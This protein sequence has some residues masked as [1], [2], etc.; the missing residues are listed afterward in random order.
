MQVCALDIKRLFWCAKS[1]LGQLLGQDLQAG[2]VP[3][4]TGWSSCENV[5]SCQLK[6][7]GN[8]FYVTLSGQWGLESYRINYA[9]KR[10]NQ[11]WGFPPRQP[12]WAVG[13]QWDCAPVSPVHGCVCSKG[14]HK[15][16]PRPHHT[17]AGSVIVLVKCDHVISTTHCSAPLNWARSSFCW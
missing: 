15:P 3:R 8:H 12:S 2:G 7:K 5:S 6:R 16:Q 14:S 11:E 9:V 13:E 4:G 17:N 10:Q 1:N